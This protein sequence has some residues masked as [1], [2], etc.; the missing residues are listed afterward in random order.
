MFFHETLLKTYSVELTH[1]AKNLYNQT[2]WTL[3]E[4][5]EATGL[6]FSYP[7][8]DKAMKQVENREINYSFL[9]SAVYQQILRIL[10][11]NFKSFFEAIQDFKNN[12]SK[13]KGQPRSSSFKKSQYDNLIYN[14]CAFQIKGGEVILD[15][16]KGNEL[17]IPLPKQLIGKTIKQV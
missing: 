2:L 5:F 10:D 15:R 7:K 6:Y 14:Y 9:K 16:T 12:P 13:Y 3:R 17:K 11:N 8:M 4:A 1:H